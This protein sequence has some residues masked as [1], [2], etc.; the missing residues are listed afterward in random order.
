MKTITSPFLTMSGSKRGKTPDTLFSQP[1]YLTSGIYLDP[2]RH[3]LK[4]ELEKNKQIIHKN[5]FKVINPR[6][7]E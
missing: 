7:V 1:E 5:P 2:Y 4:Q 6:K 3:K